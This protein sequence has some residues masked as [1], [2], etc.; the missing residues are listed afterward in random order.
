MDTTELLKKVRRIEIK[1]KGLSNQIFS[2]EYQTAF[3]GRGMNFSEVRE[4]Q[5][6]DDVRAI[7]WNVT[8]RFSHPYI[9]VFEE[10]RELTLMLL[11][12]ISRSALFGTQGQNKKELITEIAAVLAFS[13]I[14]NNDKVGVIFFSNK[15]EKYIPPKKGKAHILLIIRELLSVEPEGQGTNIGEALRFFTNANK[16]RAIVFLASDF[17]DE[18]YQDALTLASKR[19]DLIGL[20]V[21]DKRDR[22]LPKV[23]LMKMKDLETGKTK[24]VDTSGKRIRES[25]TKRFDM[26]DAYCREAFLKSGASL[27]NMETGEDYVKKLKGFFKK[28][29]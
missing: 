9:K 29:I 26:H 8:A 16:K 17:L 28:R 27:I 4:Y 21:F 24:W 3:K 19:H 15:I 6:G 7:D 11:V 18:G 10:E 14:N 20:H 23:G 13:A 22:E 25:Y 12:D 5:Y 1:T 2:G